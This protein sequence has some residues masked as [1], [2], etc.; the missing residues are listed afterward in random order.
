MCYQIRVEHN[1]L[2]VQLTQEYTLGRAEVDAV[3]TVIRL[4]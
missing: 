3:D 2:T 1:F 4:C